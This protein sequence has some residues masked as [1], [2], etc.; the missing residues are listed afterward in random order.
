MIEMGPIDWER[1]AN[2]IG[3][4]GGL[5]GVGALLKHFFAS[6]A[7]RLE[8]RRKD[9]DELRAEFSRQIAALSLEIAALKK[10]IDD[11]SRRL[12][13]E[14]RGRIDAS[15]LLNR[16]CWEFDDLLRSA[17]VIVGDN[18]KGHVAPNSILDEIEARPNARTV[19]DEAQRVISQS[20]I[21]PLPLEISPDENLPIKPP[22]LPHEENEGQNH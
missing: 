7:L 5:T 14:Q 8:D 3:L 15:N 4:A 18:R 22:I 9:R 17:K 10:Q 21:V 19:L 11:L 1:A 2:L 12:E 20:V 6:A 16:M 13:T